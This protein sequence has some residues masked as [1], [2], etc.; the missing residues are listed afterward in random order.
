MAT[1]QPINVTDSAADAIRTRLLE[2][3]E[4]V[5]GLRVGIKARGCSGMAY[6]MEYAKEADSDDE[7]VEKGDIKVFID[8][9]SMMYLLGTTI[10]YVSTDTE[11]GFTFI[12]PNEK[13]K[14]GCGESFST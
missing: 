5:V 2:A 10:D 7:V 14:C 8:P 1:T 3:G 13:S 6:F 9:S 4:G 12:N 11:E